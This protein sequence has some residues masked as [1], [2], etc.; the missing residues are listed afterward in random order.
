MTTR[1]LTLSGLR[2]KR[3]PI[4]MQLD[5]AD[6]GPTCLRII[7]EHH[8]KAY[9]LQSLR[10]RSF[11]GRDG[12][13]ILGLS[14]AAEQIG[15][16]TLSVRI[17][18]EKFGE[19]PLPCIAHWRQKHFVV[20]HKL[21]GDKVYVADPAHG[22]ITYSAD[23]FAEGWISSDHD[24]GVLLLL[25]PTAEF[26]RGEDQPRAFGNSLRFLYG[27]LLSHRRDLINL[28]WLT[29]LGSVAQ[30]VFPFLTQL[31]VDVGIRSRDFGIIYLL[32]LAQLLLYLGSTM[33]ELIQGRI[34]LRVGTRINISII[35]DFLAKLMRL[36]ISFFDS[37]IIGDILQRINDH[38]RIETFLTTTALSVLEAVITLTAFSMVLA[39]YNA[40]VFVIF[41]VASILYAAWILLFMRK[42]KE[43][44]YKRFSQ[45]T[46]NQNSL[47]QIVHGM[48]EIKLNSCERR[49]RWEWQQIQEKL[50]TVNLAGLLLEQRQHVGASAINGLKNVAITLFT[51]QQVVQGHMTLGMLMSVQFMIGRMNGPIEQLLNFVHSGQD[52]K[53]SLERLA[54]IH[55]RRDE[56]DLPRAKPAASPDGQALNLCGVTFQYMG[57]HSPC[58]L[59]NVAL[60]IPPGKVTAIV[61]VSG[62]GKTTLIKLL[63]KFYQPAQ[64]A[65]RLGDMDLAD[66]DSRAWRQKCGVV[67]QDSYIFTDTIAANIAL[68]EDTIDEDKLR[69]AAHIAHIADF[70]EALPLGYSTK[71]GTDGYGLSQ[72]QQQRILIARAVYKNPP[73]L[74]FDEATNALD[75]STEKI[76]VKNLEAFFKGKTV[77][78]IAHRLSTVRRAAQIVVLDAGR[79]VEQGTHQELT[80][81]RG[82]YYHLVKDQL[83]LGL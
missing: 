69:R 17:P 76:I 67:M 83:E 33:G 26:F 44:D 20:V 30:M 71:I 68:A 7:A 3:F 49:K 66:I 23:E 45:L 60:H 73:Y 37:R 8:G 46:N 4:H 6:C 29:L 74:F 77:I 18:Y 22:L 55:G 9:T 48:Q 15:L 64:G 82:A 2:R 11:A 43:L 56:E 25:E 27:Y 34:L 31:L 24:E 72:G 54:E 70:I 38:Y 21:M 52:A 47:I 62:S 13:S 39:L 19:M 40:Q 75:A 36:P 81:R 5:T 10:E 28:L 1:A 41:L 51:V 59:S 53:I 14:E 35:S 32:L 58:V 63:L 78:V 12:T 50:Y 65:I 80:T 42:R 16:R 57:P 61:G 79:I